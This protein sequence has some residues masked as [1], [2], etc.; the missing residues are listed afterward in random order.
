MFKVIYGKT[1][2][3]NVPTPY[4]IYKG[5]RDAIR[6]VN[7]NLGYSIV[8]NQYCTWTTT[9]TLKIKYAL[10]TEIYVP[11]WQWLDYKVW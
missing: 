4:Y 11:K 9:N 1:I 7:K 8:L 2:D 10:V 3:N 6:K 5:A